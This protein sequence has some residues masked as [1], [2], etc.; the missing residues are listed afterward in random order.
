MVLITSIVINDIDNY[1]SI[2]RKI[3]NNNINFCFC[4]DDIVL[5]DIFVH[6]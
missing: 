6:V 4:Y 1:D 5:Y 2:H 3:K